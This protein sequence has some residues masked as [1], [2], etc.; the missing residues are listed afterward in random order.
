MPVTPNAKT[1]RGVRYGVRNVHIAFLDETEGT[2]ESPIAL[3]GC[4]SL[5]TSPEG[6]TNK[7]FADDIV[8]FIARKNNGYTGEL[9]L[10]KFDLQ[11][12]AEAQGWEY[13]EENDILYEVVG[14]TTQP[15]KF[16]LLFEVEGDL[17][18]T[19][20]CYYNVTLDRPEHEWATT[21]DETEPTTETCGISID[22]LLVGD[23]GY[24]KA[25]AELTEK[26]AEK[27]N[28]WFKSV[29]KPTLAGIGG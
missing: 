7:W 24:I 3:P 2:Y 17:S 23:K 8:Y 19:R 27:W 18:N 9:E 22:Q 6:D 13:D 5:S 12:M 10:T 26:N 16:A 14:G 1:A 28:S 11:V 25:M 4:R 20:F 21:E 15:R 29:E